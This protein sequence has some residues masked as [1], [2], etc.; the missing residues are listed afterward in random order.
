METSTEKEF[1]PLPI[2]ANVA[3]IV[4]AAVDR[5]AGDRGDYPLLVALACVEALKQFQIEARVMYGAV[6]W[7]EI[8]EDQTPVWAGCWGE[9]FHFWVATQYGEVVDLNT[10]VAHRRRAHSRPDLKAQYSPPMLW[11][12][13]IPKFYRYQPEGVAEV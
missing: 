8:L 6:A 5:V 4:T 7:I 1:T 13:E 3:R 9:H 10:S 11:A 2:I 12:S